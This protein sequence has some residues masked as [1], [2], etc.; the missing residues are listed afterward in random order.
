MLYLSNLIIAN[1]IKHLPSPDLLPSDHS[2]H[3]H[4]PIVAMPQECKVYAALFEWLPAALGEG[5]HHPVPLVFALALELRTVTQLQ[6]FYA[7]PQFLHTTLKTT[8]SP[9]SP[10]PLSFH[11]LHR[12][13]S[14]FFFLQLGPL[15]SPRTSPTYHIHCAA[16]KL[17][18]P[19][20][21]R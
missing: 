17:Q 19:H 20:Q 13:I 9:L 4:D 10:N 5:S 21:K 16:S 11:Y 7:T 18:K 8:V 1:I 12:R 6:G 14:S 2:Y 3:S 15:Y